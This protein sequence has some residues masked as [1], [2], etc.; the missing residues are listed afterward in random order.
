MK[1]EGQLKRYDNCISLGWFC[2]TASS[3]SRYGLRSHSGP[4]DWYYSKLDSVLK[5]ME[6]DFQD[7]MKK[8]N[9]LIDSKDYRVFHDIKYGFR[10]NHDVQNDFEIEYSMIYRKY[11]RR[12]EYFMASVQQP[13]CFIRTVRSEEEIK[14]IEENKDYIYKVIKRSNSNNEIIF[15]I[16]RYMRELPNSYI[17]FRLNIEQYV[18]R[19]YEMR[20]MF[21]SSEDFSEYCKK[22]ILSD[23]NMKRNLKY[24]RIYYKELEFMRKLSEAD[25]DIGSIFKE[26]YPDIDEGGGISMGSG[27]LWN[28]DIE[29]SA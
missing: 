20:H 4:F 28:R 12:A 16:L 2:G 5:V 24:D 18:G 26:F 7:F 9:L 13:T 23:R 14:F 8:E 29:A 21:D 6:T 22:H 19:T 3:M 10:F 1:M 11:M 25:F 15:L 17:W 27:Y